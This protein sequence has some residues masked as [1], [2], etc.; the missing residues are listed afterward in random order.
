MR[1]LYCHRATIIMALLF[2]ANAPAGPFLQVGI[3]KTDITP[4]KAM[5]L[6]GYSSRT[7]PF[8][9]VYD[10]LYCRT[11]IFDDGVTKAAIVSLDLGRTPPGH[12]V[13]TIR[14]HA[15]AKYGID[16]LLLC[17]THTHAAPNL[18]PDHAPHPW[19]K[20]VVDN[21][22]LSIEKAQRRMQPALFKTG[23]G[24]VDITY[25]RRVINEDGSVTMLW[26]NHEREFTHSV[27]QRI[28][29][30]QI[31]NTQSQ[32]IAT[33]VHY[34]CHPV[35]SGNKNMRVS[36]EI[37]GVICSYVG[38]QIG[39]ECLFLQGACGEI[40]PYL[41]AL[42]QQ[43]KNAYSQLVEEAEKAA[44]EIVK[45][46]QQAKPTDAEDYAI[47][48]KDVPVS[49]GF[50]HALTDERLT[51]MLKTY[52]SEAQWEEISQPDYRMRTSLSLLM[53]GDT[54]AWAGFPGEFFDDF[55]VELADHSPVAHTFF[56]G[57]CNGYYAYFPTI[58]AAAQGG[59][60][61]SW[62]LIAEAGAGEQFVDQA[63]IGLYQ[64]LDKL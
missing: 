1:I 39:G 60:G 24:S 5:P 12:W 26:D 58:Q 8:S 55:Q 23:Q 21:I 47:R 42:L 57:Y 13:D 25:D 43:D 6:W 50:R 7:D 62:G 17:A 10:P 19:I 20:T 4:Q 35:I 28:K 45:I 9:G 36:A 30:L 38:E 53:L 51:K 64:L 31:N 46:I 14:A 22:Y 61:A 32:P 40:N 27:D 2:T 44:K 56:V 59:Y 37:P 15:K 48:Y 41:A 18:G 63:I 52:F 54:F 33:L 49:F 3:D 16:S 34:A 11:L 29:V